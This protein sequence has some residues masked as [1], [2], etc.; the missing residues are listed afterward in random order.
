MLVEKFKSELRKSDSKF[1]RLFSPSKINRHL[2]VLLRILSMAYENGIV[3]NN[4][5][6]RVKRIREPE[7]RQ[8]YLNQY[9][10]DEEERLMK[11]PAAYGEHVV[12]LTEVDLEV[13]MRLGELLNAGWRAGPPSG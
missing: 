13:G 1:K 11:A 2:Q 4:P 10:G 8:R 5:M 7:P 12:A 9:A 3:D 6:S